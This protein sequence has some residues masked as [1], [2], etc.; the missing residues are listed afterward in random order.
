MIQSRPQCDKS[1]EL[2]TQTQAVGQSQIGGG[3]CR[4][5]L[6][7]NA[8]CHWW[9]EIVL[10]RAPSFVALHELSLTDERS[11][12]IWK[13]ALILLRPSRSLINPGV[14]RV[15]PGSLHSLRSSHGDKQAG[16]TLHNRP[17]GLG[18][19][20]DRG[21]QG[22]HCRQTSKRTSGRSWCIDGSAWHWPS[23]STRHSPSLNRISLIA[24]HRGKT[25]QSVAQDC[26]H[27]ERLSVWTGFLGGCSASAKDHLGKAQE[28]LSSCTSPGVGHFV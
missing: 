25:K 12:R 1:C 6:C 4:M 18:E 13:A 28:D 24:I 15:P 19:T 2:R 26:P 7:L 5:Q 20:L 3:Q 11:E 17:L 21:R 16:T 27:A 23:E 14:S 9:L 8:S 22:R 10:D